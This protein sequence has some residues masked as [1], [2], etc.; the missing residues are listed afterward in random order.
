MIESP[1]R[2]KAAQVLAPTEFDLSRSVKL[3]FVYLVPS[4][5]YFD[6]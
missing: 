4:N 3:L 1:K 2:R 6:T 5:Q